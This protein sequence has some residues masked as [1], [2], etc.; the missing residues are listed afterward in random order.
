[1][2]MRLRLFNIGDI[3]AGSR[4]WFAKGSLSGVAGTVIYQRT[5][6]GRQTCWH[7]GH[8]YNLMAFRRLTAPWRSVWVEV[9][10]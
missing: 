1:M 8:D 7:I 4:F 10:Q 2:K 6:R 3:P 9:T 5:K